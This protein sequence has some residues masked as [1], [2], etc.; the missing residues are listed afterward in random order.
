M[1]SQACLSTVG[2]VPGP[3]WGEGIPCTRSLQGFGIPEGMSR[4]RGLGMSRGGGGYA[5]YQ[6][7]FAGVGGGEF[8]G[9]GGYVH[10]GTHPLLWAWDLGYPPRRPVAVTKQAIRI[11]LECF[12]VEWDFAYELNVKT[13]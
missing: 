5:R 3:F 11:L 13:R 1:V 8:Q 12:L 6:V 9:M 10:V 4:G 2:L 7:H